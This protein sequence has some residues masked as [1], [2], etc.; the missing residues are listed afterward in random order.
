MAGRDIPKLA[1]DYLWQSAGLLGEKSK[2][3]NNGGINFED[4]QI[5]GIPSCVDRML[6]CYIRLLTVRDPEEYDD[7]SKDFLNYSALGIA[8][9]KLGAPISIFAA[10]Y[11]NL[12]TKWGAYENEPM[13]LPNFNIRKIPTEAFG[14]TVSALAQ[15]SKGNGDGS[16]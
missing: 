9:V 14:P 15:S 6:E 8:Y 4:Y 1:I 12:L 10:V 5:N 7:K 13:P 3:Y 16:A 11:H 2:V